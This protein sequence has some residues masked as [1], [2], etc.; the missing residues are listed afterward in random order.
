MRY[1]LSSD[2]QRAVDTA[3]LINQPFHLPLRT[4]PYCANATG[5]N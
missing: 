1:I 4:T 3:N 5:G 2:L